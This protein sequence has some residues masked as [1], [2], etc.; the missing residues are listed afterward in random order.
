ME[1]FLSQIQELPHPLV[2]NALVR[3]IFLFFSV[4]NH[5]KGGSMLIQ[6]CLLFLGVFLPLSGG[7]MTVLL[8]CVRELFVTCLFLRRNVLCFLL[9]KKL[10]IAE[11]P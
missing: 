3:S 8:L 9:F 5:E 11:L 6:I 2:P 10:F 1:R 4:L 7:A